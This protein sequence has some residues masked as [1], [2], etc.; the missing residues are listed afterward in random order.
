[1]A[2]FDDDEEQKEEEMHET[3]QFQMGAGTGVEELLNE[4][5]GAPS[6]SAP[7]VPDSVDET[8]KELMQEQDAEAAPPASAPSAADSVVDET[9]TAD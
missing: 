3:E 6:A 5:E 2:T 8:I 4:E 1:M 7:S 9:S